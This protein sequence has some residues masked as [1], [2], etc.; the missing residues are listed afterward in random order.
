MA[1]P[2]GQ[3]QASLRALEG[4]C[5]SGLLILSI[6][7]RYRL[8]TLLIVLAVG[9]PV[10][11]GAWFLTALDPWDKLALLNGMCAALPII[12]ILVGVV[13][14]DRIFGRRG[15]DGKSN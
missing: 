13:I 2:A 1:C 5:Q 4:E 3:L 15:Q 7:M 9:P 11:A 6:S 12:A 14:L 10:L 8:Q